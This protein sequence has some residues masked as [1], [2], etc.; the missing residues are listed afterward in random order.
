MV[1]IHRV[2]RHKDT[3]GS[4]Y[5]AIHECFYHKPTDKIPHSWTEDEISPIGES[6]ESL[7]KTLQRMNVACQKP[8]LE[9]TEDGDHLREV[10][11]DDKEEANKG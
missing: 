2:I 3:D 8:T 6:I 4:Y 1:W 10:N 7:L 9:I 11:V 5:Y